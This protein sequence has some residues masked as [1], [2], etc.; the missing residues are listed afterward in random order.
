[1]IA[2]LMRMDLNAT[3]KFAEDMKMTQKNDLNIMQIIIDVIIEM[4]FG[5]TDTKKKRRRR[6]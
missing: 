2:A 1:M 6:R 3:V 5:I 4:I